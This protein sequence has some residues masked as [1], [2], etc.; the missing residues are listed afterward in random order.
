MHR[1]LFLIGG[2]LLLL[3]GCNASKT[4]EN[5][6]PVLFTVAGKPVT[7]AEFNYVYNKNNS[8]PDNGVA[9]GSVQEYLDL[10]TNFKLKVT[11]A[12]KRG[13]D[14][15]TAFRKELE[16][17]KEQLA[18]PY[19]T[20]KNVTDQLVKEAYER[21]KQEVNA[22]HI[23]VN[24]APDADP[25]DTLAAY[26]KIMELRRRIE[27]GE[28][29]NTIAR[30]QSDD[31]SAK[32]NSGNLGY[33]TALQMLYPFEKAAYNTTKGQL[34]MPIRTRFG[35]HL[36]KVNDV[37]PAQGEIK[38]AHIM[39]R[40]T[41]GIPKADSVVA[42]RKI[43]AIY[44]R[45][46]RKEN[47]DKITAQFSED[48]SS[49]T[50]GGELPWFGTGRMLPSFE[51]A[52]FKL[53]AVGDISK[54]VQT[55][56]GWHIIKLIER[57]SLPA[58]EEMESY[59]R[60]KVAK[61]SRSELNKTAFLKR[62]KQEDN[63]QE[64]K[65]AR[66][67]A[68]SKA[69]DSLTTGTWHY[70]DLDKETKE[71]NQTL[72]TLQDRQFTVK[73]FFTYV[74]KNQKSVLN[75]S[76]GH[77]MN[78][79]YDNYVT[80]TLL[81]YEREN[82]ESK[83]VDY[84]MLVNEY[85]DGILLFQLMDE[86]VWSKAIQDTVGLQAF[87]EQNKENYK[88]D[89]RADAIVIN[90]ANKDILAQAQQLL[91]TGKYELKK[92][93]PEPILF[94]VGKDVL[95]PENTEQLTTLS[96]RLIGDPLLTI[97]LT[98]NA[99]MKESSGK[100][101]NLANRR[102]QQVATFLKGKGVADTRITVTANKP[103]SINATNRN[104]SFTLYTSDIKGIE[105][106]LNITNPLAVQVQNKRF[107]KGENKI[108]DEITW[109]VGTYNLEKDGRSVFIK[110]NK[111]LPPGYKNLNEVRGIATSDYQTYLEKEWLKEL[112]QK[113]SVQVNQAEVQ[114]LTQK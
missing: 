13:L 1:S 97:T 27:A 61:D 72:F 79:L 99:D 87:F 12:E 23:L 113:Y 47:W 92:S 49:A 74:Q 22:S 25:K 3:A 32:E 30:T 53:T 10:Y 60:S 71:L 103:K 75:G 62:I 51:E 88:W 33:F 29:F 86:K 34:S 83:Y 55:P 109:Q 94:S 66:D 91:A 111:I 56:Y 44:N 85:R 2:T 89:I 59:L 114:K 48:A 107:Q 8:Q 11:E 31:P 73:D 104:V 35:Y 41:P 54:P 93:R 80:T 105:E 65:A 90:A 38:V 36:I 9:K 42:K 52:A 26:N 82:L 69:T 57:R 5:K 67:F 84:K 43:D 46:A 21:M 102:A 112:R 76:A 68:L 40:A 4:P 18:Q 95:T 70:T 58:F 28:D 101:A 15:T 78:V 14:T 6:E 81:N 20:E 110:I 108:L 17:Y 63:F 50:N 7:T 100:N 45:L 37:R 64:I 106:T 96:D 98:G 19:L 39:V 77:V 24:V 16:G